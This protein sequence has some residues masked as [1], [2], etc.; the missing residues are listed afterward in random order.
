MFLKSNNHTVSKSVLITFSLLLLLLIGCKKTDVNSSKEPDAA[1][2]QE[3]IIER[4]EET[5]NNEQAV[6]TA[7]EASDNAEDIDKSA[8]NAANNSNETEEP[9][10]ENA[11]SQDE[12]IYE[13]TYEDE[14]ESEEVDKGNHSLPKV[15][16]LGDSLTQGAL[17]I[18]NGNV[19][20]PQ[21]PWRV[22]ASKYGIDITGYGYYGYVTHDIFWKF[23]EDGGLRDKN[24][25]YI[26]WVGANDFVLSDT[27]VYDVIKETNQFMENG[28]IDKYVIVGTTDRELLGHDKA[29]EINALLKKTYGSH[30]VDIIDCLEFGPDGSH[31]T[32]DSYSKV[33]DTVYKKL[34]SLYSK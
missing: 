22:I 23:G 13:G 9:E 14:D 31:L 34:I 32:V 26:F 29:I 1:P 33:A 17:D 8:D 21:A 19:N 6:N 25:V 5:A 28:G 24:N 20:N 18:D 4:T 10:S 7:A 15:I 11:D 30:Y 12:G 16:W 2:A 27:A 3:I